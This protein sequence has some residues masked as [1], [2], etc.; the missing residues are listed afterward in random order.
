MTQDEPEYFV[1]EEQES[2][3][4]NV[5]IL[6]LEEDDLKVGLTFETED[7]DVRSILKCTELAFCPLS[8]ARYKKPKMKENG[9]RIKGR[10]CFQSWL[11]IYKKSV[12]QSKVLSRLQQI[13][14]GLDRSI[15]DHLP[16]NFNFQPTGKFLILLIG[17]DFEA[18]F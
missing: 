2:L 15:T 9:E 11:K 10:R 1:G 16:K 8:K 17:N 4:T 14:S 5:D 6:I 13:T 7:A 3:E 12:Q 18:N